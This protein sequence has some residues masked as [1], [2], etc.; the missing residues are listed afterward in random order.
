MAISLR[1]R[2]GL[3]APQVAKRHDNGVR[4]ETLRVILVNKSEADCAGLVQHICRRYWEFACTVSSVDIGESVVEF[5]VC[6]QKVFGKCEN[7]SEP[8]YDGIA[9]IAQ[10]REGQ[11]VLLL[12]GK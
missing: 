9:D 10:H 5:P 8:A 1:G 2:G 11:I 7:Y 3:I 6:L 12:G 4:V